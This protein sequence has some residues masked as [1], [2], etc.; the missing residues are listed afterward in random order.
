[1]EAQRVQQI[2][3]VGVAD[4]VRRSRTDAE[5]IRNL[6]AQRHLQAER[7]AVLLCEA[8]AAERPAEWWVD[9]LAARD[10]EPAIRMLNAPDRPCIFPSST[11]R[12]ATSSRRTIPARTPDLTVI[13]GWDNLVIGKLLARAGPHDL[14]CYERRTRGG[15]STSRG[16]SDSSMLLRL[17]LSRGVMWPR[18]LRCDASLVP[19]P[20][21]RSLGIDNSSC[22][23][24]VG[25]ATSAHC[26]DSQWIHLAAGAVRGHR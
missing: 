8:D 17:C 22:A 9:C 21:I 15:V 1:M 12:S 11:A 14:E 13:V 3:A 2:S 26:R 6:A 20:S 4:S 5:H 24:G 19:Y 23:A 18:S 10:V 16:M 25:A 7:L